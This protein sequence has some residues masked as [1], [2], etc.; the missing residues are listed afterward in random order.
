MKPHG[1]SSGI[2]WCESME[3]NFALFV[4]FGKKK[5]VSRLLDGKMHFS[6]AE[7]FRGI[8]KGKGL[9][10]QGDAYEAIWQLK[11]TQGFFT[12]MDTGTTQ[13]L[14]N[15]NLDL[16]LEDISRIP[17]FCITHIK[18]DECLISST[19][20]KRILRV[21]DTIRDTIK[22]HFPNADTAGV[23][24]QPKMFLSSLDGLGVI[25]HDSVQYFDFSPNGAILEMIEYLFQNPGRKKEGN[26]RLLQSIL[27]TNDGKQKAMEITHQNMKRL[28]FCKDNYFSDE[29]EYRIILP[30]KRISEPKDYKIRWGAQKR[31]MYTIDEFFNGIEL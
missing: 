30:Q 6:N 19:G 27:V 21:K 23:F 15:V 29:K 31:M 11:N 13:Y 7:V 20:S 12:D 9:K 8:E 25:M 2:R 10:G 4:K 26:Q 5:H 22:A 17:V 18:T 3:N 28:L 24:F 16:Q 14:P 1:I